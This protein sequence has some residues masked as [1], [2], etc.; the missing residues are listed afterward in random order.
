MRV[1][2]ERSGPFASGSARTEPRG[3]AGVAAPHLPVAERLGADALPGPAVHWSMIN[4]LAS[5]RCL[6]SREA[7]A[8]Y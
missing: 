5:L 7:H 4:A 8:A 6:A 3:T 1:R 2:Q